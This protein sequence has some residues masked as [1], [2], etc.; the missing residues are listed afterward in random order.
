MK[1]TIS[2]KLGTFV[3][4]LKFNNLP[5]EVIDRGKAALLHN[6]GVAIA[7]ETAENFAFKLIMD[8]NSDPKE[9]TLIQNGVKVSAEGAVFAN[10]ALMHARTQD[11]YHSP[12]SSHPGSCVIPAALTTAEL[13]N[14]SGKDFLCG[15]ILGYEITGRIGS[16]YDKLASNKGFRP[17]AIYGIFGATIASSYLLN[18]PSIQII[19]SISLASNL[20]SGLCQTWVEG[21]QEWRLQ[22]ATS[23]KNGFNAARLAST[24]ITTAA[25]T[26]EGSHGFYRAFSGVDVN[27]NDILFEIGEKWKIMEVTN[28]AL[29]ICALLQSPVKILLQLIV[30]N[31][32]NITNVKK[33]DLYLS[34]FEANY[35]GINNAG[36]FSDQGG[37]LMSAQFCLSQI[38]ISKSI[39]F[40]DLLDFNSIEIFKIITKIHVHSDQNLCIQS[41]RI[42]ITTN[43]NK[44]YIKESK[45]TNFNE[46][47]NYSNT[48]K[49]I[50]NLAN[51]I[52]NIKSKLELLVDSIY[53]IDKQNN[54]NKILNCFSLH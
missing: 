23:A 32:L 18:L 49:L 15:V 46:V 50:L 6:I 26:L 41:C 42:N 17:A 14:S 39:T 35:P 24:G 9:A 25:S 53:T 36:P 30:D 22:V 47:I 20:S 2:E 40:N 27:A 8:F 44:S 5:V 12:S 16:N 28:K 31:N 37:T 38:L 52:P 21:T 54:L 10:A 45:N 7:G 48:A 34:P 11:D 51:E 29:P 43:T 13:V 19:N 4:N 33:I 3:S 1:H